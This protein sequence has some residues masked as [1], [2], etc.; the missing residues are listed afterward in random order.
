MKKKNVNCSMC[1][2]NNIKRTLLGGSGKTGAII[3]II[4]GIIGLLFMIV[5]GKP[6]TAIYLLILGFI[7]L[8]VDKYK[9][10]NCGNTF[11]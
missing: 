9:C 1:Y 10:N 7:G 4:I 11:S 5:S 6:N 2:S 8:F 3:A